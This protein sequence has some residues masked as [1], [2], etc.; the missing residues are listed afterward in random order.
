MRGRQRGRRQPSYSHGYTQTA[1]ERVTHDANTRRLLSETH[2]SMLQFD[3]GAH[4]RNTGQETDEEGSWMQAGRAQLGRLRGSVRREAEGS[5]SVSAKRST[6]RRRRPSIQY[7]MGGRWPWRHL[8]GCRSCLLADLTEHIQGVSFIEDRP[9]PQFI[10]TDPQLHC[11]GHGAPSGC[12][13]GLAGWLAGCASRSG[14]H[15]SRGTVQSASPRAAGLRGW[16]EYRR[17]VV[18]RSSEIVVVLIAVVLIVV[19]VVA[20]VGVRAKKLRESG[21]MQRPKPSPW[22]IS[23]PGASTTKI[24]LFVLSSDDDRY[25]SANANAILHARGRE[26]S[27]TTLMRTAPKMYILH[28]TTTAEIS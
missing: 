12:L 4:R 7:G 24:K 2:P 9:P 25:S 3:D 15:F 6:T 28:V 18:R 27:D 14:Q 10:R 21:S 22:H 17:L 1:H 5:P 20:G 16:G 19:A 13:A 8:Y 23:W 11:A 26:R